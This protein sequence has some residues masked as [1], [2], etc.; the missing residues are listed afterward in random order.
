MSLFY[1]D[2]P[3]T[4]EQLTAVRRWVELPEVQEQVRRA[5]HARA[6]GRTVSADE[7]WRSMTRW[8]RFRGRF[9]PPWRWPW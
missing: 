1:R 7:I 2:R 8:Q 4:A 5:E 9:G 3:P 6:E